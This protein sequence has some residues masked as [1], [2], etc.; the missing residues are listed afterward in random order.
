MSVNNPASAKMTKSGST[1]FRSQTCIPVTS[2]A[3]TASAVSSNDIIVGNSTL[4]PQ[5]SALASIHD[6]VKFHKLRMNWVPALPTT[7]GGTGVMFFD[8]DRTDV[9]PTTMQEAM[10]N[11]GARAGPL[12]AKSTYV[13]DRKML[14]SNEMF[15]T[16]SGT[17][18]NAATNNTFSGPGKVH[19]FY[20]SQPGITYTT[21]TVIGFLIVDYELEFMF[22]SA[23]TDTTVPTRRM[24]EQVR[25]VS[26]VTYDRETVM[27]YQNF[28]AGCLRPIDFYTFLSLFDLE[29]RLNIKRAIEFEPDATA[30][31][32]APHTSVS[33]SNECFRIQRDHVGDL[34]PVTNTGFSRCPSFT[35]DWNSETGSVYY[36]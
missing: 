28:Q 17:G 18:T 32:L 13:C 36:D 5:A 27:T 33:P 8:T 2:T 15:S 25:D 4:F 21:S 26:S 19:F 22:P 24:L 11:K 16:I 23:K 10:Q 30:L 20:T 14:R 1:H 6:K 31:S 29:G 12:W 34:N 9:G 7:C 35:P 3:N